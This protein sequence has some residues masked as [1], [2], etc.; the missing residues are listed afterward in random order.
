VSSLYLPL[1]IFPPLASVE[2]K[3]KVT[4]RLAVYRQSVRLG[5]K[6]L[7]T[8]DQRSFFFRLNPCGNS[9]YVTF[10]LTRRWVCLL[11]CPL[12]S[13]SESESYVTTDGQPASL[14]WNKAPFWGLRPDLD[15]CLTVA[16]LLMWGALSDERMGLE[17]AIAAGPRQRNHS[18]VQVPW[19]SRPYFTASDSRLPFLSPPKTRRATVEVFDPASTRESSCIS[20]WP[21]LCSLGADRIKV[22]TFYGSVTVSYQCVSTV[23]CLPSRS[24]VADLF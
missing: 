10:S 18:R 15:Y 5:V 19:N 21:T 4:L 9:P 3:A 23:T 24:L 8:H 22:I 6:P 17:F 2:V 1:C 7:E 13:E 14:S 20:S 12:V 16:G 11:F